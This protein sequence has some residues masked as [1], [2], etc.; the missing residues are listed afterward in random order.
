[1]LNT[2]NDKVKLLLLLSPHYQKIRTLIRRIYDIRSS[3]VWL[4]KLNDVIK[5]GTINQIADIVISVDKTFKSHQSTT[6]SSLSEDDILKNNWDIVVKF[7][8]DLARKT[9]VIEC[10]C[11]HQMLPRKDFKLIERYG[12]GGDDS[13]LKRLVQAEKSKLPWNICKTYCYKSI[14]ENVI[15]KFSIL[16]NMKMEKLPTEISSLN[17]YELLMI[18]LAKCF[19]SIYRLQPFKAKQHSEQVLG[20]KGN[21]MRS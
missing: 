9:D 5:N 15:P 10:A 21:S 20:F 1:M 8:K 19:H 12:P 17:S 3:N 7:K 16:N 2:C 4:M 13:I 11:C 18:Q 14:I 6:N